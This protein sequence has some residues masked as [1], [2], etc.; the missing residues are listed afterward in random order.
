MITASIRQ[1]DGIAVDEIFVACSSKPWY[2]VALP[3]DT[4]EKAVKAG[5]IVKRYD[6]KCEHEQKNWILDRMQDMD[7]V[8]M[9]APDMFMTKT[10]LGKLVGFLRS[11][12]A[13]DRGYGCNMLTYWR[14]L[15]H[16][17]RPSPHFASV[18]IRPKER[19]VFSSR[20]KDFER[21]PHV[22]GVAMNHL[23]WC[24]TDQEVY[25]KITSYSHAPEVATDW[26][27]RVWLAR[28]EKPEDFGPTNPQDYKYI[29]EF[30]LPDELKELL[31]KYEAIP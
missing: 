19:F 9:F 26:Y 10:S 16:I 20:F 23:S 11:G 22:A 2:G 28:E 8:L 1:F 13:K 7:W 29:E 14:D 21:F 4:A 24:R 12:E 25:N 18:A 31:K 15:D 17:I 6:W 5:A 27:E 3:D 30:H